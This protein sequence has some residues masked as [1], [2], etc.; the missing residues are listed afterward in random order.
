METPCYIINSFI[1][2][3]RKCQKFAGDIFWQI[4]VFKFWSS[5]ENLTLCGVGFKIYTKFKY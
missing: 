2:M 3:K 1:F 4:G 5:K